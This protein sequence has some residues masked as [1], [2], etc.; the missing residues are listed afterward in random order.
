MFNIITVR[1]TDLIPE[2][3]PNE[4]VFMICDFRYAICDL[5]FGEC[6]YEEAGADQ[7]SV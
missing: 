4:G 6:R 5:R 3:V 1:N 2:S 7:R